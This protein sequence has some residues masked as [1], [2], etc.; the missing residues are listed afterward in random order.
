MWDVY[1]SIF[2]KKKP[3]LGTVKQ[4]HME[5][6]LSPNLNNEVLHSIKFTNDRHLEFYHPEFLVV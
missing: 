3:M 6:D 1:I 4:F 2:K 5:T